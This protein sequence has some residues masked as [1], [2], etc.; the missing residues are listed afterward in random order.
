MNQQDE[1]LRQI[2]TAVR[3]L[4]DGSREWRKAVHQL[5]SY[6]QGLPGL[7][8]CSHPDYPEVLNDTLALVCE[9][10][11]EFQPDSASLTS[12]LVVWI[13]YKLRH[14]YRVLELYQ[15]APAHSIS[16]DNQVRTEEESKATFAEQLPDP[17][18]SNIWEL[19]AEIE[20]WQQQRNIE[21]V[22][23]RLRQ[24]IEQ[25]P[26]GKLRSCSSRK[27]P[28]CNCYLLSQRLYLRNPPDNLARFASEFNVPYQTVVSHWKN[29]GLPLLQA[30][31]H[32][33]GINPIKTYD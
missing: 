25:D 5:L 3:Q 14:K 1:R 29:K 22:G 26:E 17:H 12:S 15:Y 8:R 18:P 28:N 11:Q 24:Y 16:I 23:T 13:N 31:A 2:I 10:I 7:A 6:I 20:R 21:S 30:I 4:A 27:Y 9:K 33:L 32:E 19:E